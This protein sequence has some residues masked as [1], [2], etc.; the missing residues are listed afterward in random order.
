L[1]VI[2]RFRDNFSILLPISQTKRRQFFDPVNGGVHITLQK[3]RLH[4]SSAFWTFH[5][6]SPPFPYVNYS[7]VP[8]NSSFPN[9]FIILWARN[10]IKVSNKE[11]HAPDR[12]GR[13]VRVSKPPVIA[14]QSSLYGFAVAFF[15]SEPSEFIP[16][17]DPVT[18][19]VQSKIPN[20]NAVQENRVHR[21]GI[22]HGKNEYL[23]QPWMRC[24]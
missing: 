16:L 9:C 11:Q 5:I 13:G 3:T 19:A 15:Q 8:T 24:R 18:M 4:F 14:N 23:R 12:S 17:F 1:A 2:K 6:C 7:Q 20:Q 22:F 21:R 10:E